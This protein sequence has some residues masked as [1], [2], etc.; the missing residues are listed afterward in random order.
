[1]KQTNLIINDYDLYTQLRGDMVFKAVFESAVRYSLSTNE[2]QFIFIS[3]DEIVFDNYVYEESD[4][5]CT[6]INK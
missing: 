4:L 2:T 6:I 3:K 5:I 1:M